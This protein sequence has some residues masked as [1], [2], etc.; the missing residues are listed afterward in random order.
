MFIA[1]KDAVVAVD[2]YNLSGYFNSYDKAQTVD[3]LETTCFGASAKTFIP[4]L[5]DGTLSLAGLYDGASGAVDEVL[6][7]ALAASAGKV[8]SLVPAGAAIGNRA[9][10]LL[11]NE[12]SYGISGAVAD[13]VSVS[14]EFQA[15]G[16]I[17]GGVALN[18]LTAITAAGNQTAVDNTASSASGAIA[19]VHLI[20]FTGTNIT[21]KVQHST[22]NTT[23]ADLIS[24]TALTAA[25]Q[26]QKTAAGTV[27]RYA[28]LNISGTFTSAVL[29]VTFARL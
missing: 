24:F 12:T 28:R 8:V 11:A 17:F 6:Q 4:G 18:T 15:T 1:A 14:A 16:G 27:N 26:E 20:A 7:A 22:D 21:A 10:I 25:G 29:L 23:F 9:L 3:P 5:K 2:Q 13:L 19:N